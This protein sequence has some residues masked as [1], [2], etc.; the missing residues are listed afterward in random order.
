M[1]YN[2]L[3]N[4]VLISGTK[5]S[6]RLLSMVYLK[7]GSHFSDWFS[8]TAGVRQGGVLSPEFYCIYVDDLILKLK[9]QGIGCH[10]RGLFAAALF[11]ADDMAILS[12]SLK[13][14]QALLDICSIYHHKRDICLNSN[15]TKNMY[16][17]KKKKKTS[18]TNLSSNERQK[19]Y[20][21]SCV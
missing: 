5:A 17:G 11:Y 8:V 7:W 21:D 18:L 14:L 15:K 19:V 13:G 10:V 2:Q 9:S 20:H 16:F 12:P 6:I 1:Q 3:N 4:L